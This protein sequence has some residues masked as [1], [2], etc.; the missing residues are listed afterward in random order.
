[1]VTPLR[2]GEDPGAGDTRLQAF[3][4]AAQPELR[5]FLPD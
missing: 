4:R 2:K 5:S 3:A 1:L